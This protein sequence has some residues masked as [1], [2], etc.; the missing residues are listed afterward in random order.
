MKGRDKVDETYQLHSG[1][2]FGNYE[3]DFQD[4]EHFIGQLSSSWG[5]LH[6]NIPWE[7]SVALSDPL[8]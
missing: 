4:L 6:V 8:A 3:E 2:L 5:F 1:K 7:E